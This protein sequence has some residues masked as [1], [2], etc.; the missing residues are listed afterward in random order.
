VRPD[1]LNRIRALEE[2]VA[3]VVIDELN[4]A[5]WPGAETPIAS[6]TR[7]DRG[8]RAWT[9]KT[10]RQSMGLLMDTAKLVAF[11]D[12]KHRTGLFPT[13]DQERDEERAIQRFEERANA[14]LAQRAH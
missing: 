13:A 14:V 8:D 5:E 6:M 2:K 1:Q 9:V 11:W 12:E 3:D 4:P 7:E 10:V